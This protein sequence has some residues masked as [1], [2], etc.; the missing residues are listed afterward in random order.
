M[1]ERLALLRKPKSAKRNGAN[2]IEEAYGALTIQ[3]AMEE[4][5]KSRIKVHIHEWKTVAEWHWQVED[6]RC[7]ICRSQY[8]ACPPGVKYPGDDCPPGIY[9]I[10]QS[11]LVLLLMKSCCLPALHLPRPFPTSRT[12]SFNLVWGQCGH[13][14]HLQCINEWIKNNN[15][16]PLNVPHP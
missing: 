3:L 6:E 2:R 10:V 14:F 16:C 1:S 8:D 5:Q 9:F 4:K 12:S 15:T 11:A 7:G 13:A